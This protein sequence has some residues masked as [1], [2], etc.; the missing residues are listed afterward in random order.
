VPPVRPP[1]RMEIVE[2]QDVREVLFDGETGRPIRQETK[3][4]TVSG[5]TLNSSEA[6]PSP[7]GDDKASESF[8]IDFESP[9]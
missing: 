2:A 3:A 1:F 9:K 6:G 7:T 5:P 8:P 4:S